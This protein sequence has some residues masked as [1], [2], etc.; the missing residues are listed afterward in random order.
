MV[1][2]SEQRRDLLRRIEARRAGVQAFLRENRPRIRRRANITI[3][4]TS[5]S[6][7]FTAG[8]ALGGETFAKSV[9]NGLGLATDSVV[10]RVL[11]LL[12]M[13]VSVTAAVLANIAKSQDADARLS[14]AEAA[15]A[16]LEGL[17]TLLHF[18]HLSVDDGVKL[19]QQYAGKIPFVQDLVP[20][21]PPGWGPPPSGGWGQQ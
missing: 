20:T 19:Y 11:C 3:V 17:A 5:L 10:W 14:T 6:A 12:A 7:V 15:N 2:D 8:P 13:L 16:E 1:E 4:L 21:A 18:G 9:Q